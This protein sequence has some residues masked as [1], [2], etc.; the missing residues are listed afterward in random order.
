MNNTGDRTGDLAVPLPPTFD[1][2]SFPL[3]PAPPPPSPRPEEAKGMAPIRYTGRPVRRNAPCHCG[4]GK[5]YK[6]CCLKKVRGKGI[7]RRGS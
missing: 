5:K 3:T 7:L 2:G 1:P 4:S 6:A